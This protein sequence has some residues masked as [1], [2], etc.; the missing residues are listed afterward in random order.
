M[1]IFTDKAKERIRFFLQDKNPKEWGVR[2]RS[3]GPDQY[4][5][6]LEAIDTVSP[7]DSIAPVDELNV[8]HAKVLEEILKDATIDYVETEWSRGFKVKLK[9]EE[10]APAKGP[11]LSNPVAKKIHDILTNEINPLIA[12][13]G[14]V[15]ELLD[16]KDHVVYLKMGGGCQGCGG[17]SA[18]LRNGIELRLKEEIPEIVEVRDQTDHAAGE[19]PYF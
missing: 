15:A 13:H 18:T 11:D 4:G 1:M 9:G 17:V 10:N 2:I 14:G 19:N 8:I 6:S 7:L 12:S 16:Y 5:F 3:L